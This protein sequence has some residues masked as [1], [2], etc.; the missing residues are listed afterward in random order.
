MKPRDLVR[1]TDAQLQ[2]LIRG[3]LAIKR[4]AR[5]RGDIEKLK[6]VKPRIEMVMREIER[7]REDKAP[8]Q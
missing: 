8:S 5:R 1:L 4:V 7:R 6:R 2:Q 3:E